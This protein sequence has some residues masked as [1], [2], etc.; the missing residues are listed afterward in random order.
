MGVLDVARAVLLIAE[1]V[2]GLFV[3]YLCI[4][5]G[6]AAV[7][8]YAPSSR[9]RRGGD[10]PTRAAT[11]YVIVIPAHNE[12]LIIENLLENL[13]ALTYPRERYTICV[14]A[15]NCTDGTA[16]IARAHEHEGVRVYERNDDTRRGKGFALRWIFER[17]EVERLNYH[18]CLVLDA[19]AVVEANALDVFAQSLSQGAQAVQGRYLV[20]NPRA[21]ASSALRWVALALANHVRPLGRYTLGASASITG[22]GFCLTRELLQTHPWSA[23]GLAEDYQYYLSLVE[24]G[25]RVHYALDAHIESAMPT[26]FQQMRTQDVRWESM[27]AG[28][29]PARVIAWRLFGGWLRT[30]DARRL[31]ALIELITPSLSLLGLYSALLVIAAGL[32]RELLPLAGA[33]GLIVGLCLYVSSAFVLLHPPIAVY[34]ALLFA[35]WFALRK[36]WIILVVSRRKRETSAWVRTSREVLNGK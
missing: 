2:A 3:L 18:A 15:D 20:L 1:A 9:T 25:I 24:S 30:R 23:F 12:E 28:Q 26:T 29:T 35:P 21:S 16:A 11:N 5:A 17:I 13:R 7:A 19:D 27:G 10:S 34:R 8:T 33:L 14:V 6:A 32:L 36:A 31:E 22:N 4:L